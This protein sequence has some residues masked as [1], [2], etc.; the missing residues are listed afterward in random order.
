MQC[1]LVRPGHLWRSVLERLK[2]SDKNVCDEKKA[3]PSFM[4]FVEPSQYATGNELTNGSTGNVNSLVVCLVTLLAHELHAVD[5]QAVHNGDIV[6]VVEMVDK[7][8]DDADIHARTLKLLER[9]WVI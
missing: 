9:V 3:L 7:R 5:K 2:S 8:S 6:W 4:V 1:D